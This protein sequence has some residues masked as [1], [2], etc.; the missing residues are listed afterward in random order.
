MDALQEPIS[1]SARTVHAPGEAAAMLGAS[2]A[3]FTAILPDESKDDRQNVCVQKS[4]SAIRYNVVE[5]TNAT[6]L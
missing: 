3:V 6:Q 5:G 1:M 2:S 4:M